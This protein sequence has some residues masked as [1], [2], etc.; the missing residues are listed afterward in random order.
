MLGFALEKCRK[1]CFNKLN[2]NLGGAEMN[3]RKKIIYCIQCGKKLIDKAVGD[4]GE[5]RYCTDCNKFYF[6]NPISCVIA[7]II[8]EKNRVLMLKQNYIST[9]NYTLCSGYLK[10]GDTLEE[11]VVREVFEE[12][13]QRV[14]SCEYVKSYYFVPKN[15][16]MAGFIA[17]VKA[18]AFGVSNEVDELLWADLE[19]AVYMV[20]RENNYSGTHL[21]NCIEKMKGKQ[22]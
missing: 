17:Y 7:A 5:Q 4:E 13:G 22:L 9:E 15:L 16:I 6:D 1:M 20:E 21:D 8:D 2:C 12:T 10:K 14:I 3:S 11:T 18:D 19:E